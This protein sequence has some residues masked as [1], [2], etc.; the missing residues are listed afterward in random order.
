MI[1]SEVRGLGAP[2]ASLFYR[3]GPGRR[4]G[5][6]KVESEAHWLE[7][8]SRFLAAV[9]RSPQTEAI[10]LHAAGVVASCVAGTGDRWEEKPYGRT[11]EVPCSVLS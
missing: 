3:H 10:V 7:L 9:P 4:S 11:V 6:Q 8:R 5:L 1:G 2:V